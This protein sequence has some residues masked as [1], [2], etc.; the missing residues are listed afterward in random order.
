[1]ANEQIINEYL[2]TEDADRINIEYQSTLTED[3]YF[4]MSSRDRQ[5]GLIAYAYKCGREEERNQ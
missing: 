2:T 1:M 5:W 4:N 3:E